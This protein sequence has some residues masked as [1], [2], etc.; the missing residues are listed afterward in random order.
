[1]LKNKSLISSYSI[2]TGLVL[3][4]DELKDKYL[5]G[6]PMR[7]KDGKEISNSSVIDYIRSATD[8][9]ET[10][11][12][13]KFKKQVFEE[14]LNFSPEDY[15]NWGYLQVTYPVVCALN[16]EGYLNTTKQV[17]YPKQWLSSR[18]TS[19]KILYHRN[20]YI[21]PAGDATGITQAQLFAGII[22]NL[23][24]LGYGR[25]PNYWT[26]RYVTGFDRIPDM[27]I[28]IIG[29][30]AAINILRLISDLILQ[31]G[32]QSFSL[33]IDGLSQSISSKGY[34][35]RIKGYLDD[36]NQRLLPNAKDYYKGYIFASC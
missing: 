31:P 33:G 17:T 14:S 22:P 23:S 12:N 2:N 25:I 21:V 1:M 16:L 32:V 13:L 4:T 35:T 8:Q 10:Y 27:L 28:E 20:V 29:K 26:V 18:Q 19:D 3:S 5:F 11:L 24:Y 34:D 7:T 30:L 9:L 15:S 36:L 6:T